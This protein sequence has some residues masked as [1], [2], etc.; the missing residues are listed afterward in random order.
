MQAPVFRWERSAGTCAI[1][2]LLGVTVL[3]HGRHVDVQHHA[4]LVGLD[5]HLWS[6]NYMLYMQPYAQSPESG[7]AARV[8]FE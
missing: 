6:C 1:C 8:R 2:N 3:D 5:G 7:L 4:L